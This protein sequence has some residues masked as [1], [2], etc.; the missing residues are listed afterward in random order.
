M[1]I[2]PT[3][4]F[5]QESAT[6]AAGQDVTLVTAPEATLGVA[7]CYDVRFPELARKMTLA[8]AKILIY[9]AAFGP[10]TG[11][12]H[13]ELLMRMRAVDNQ[14]FVVA[15]APALNPAANYKA[16]GHSLIVNPWGDIVAVADERERVL[17]ASINLDMIEKVRAELPLL[18]HRRPELYL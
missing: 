1:S 11:P 9:P 5:F 18:Q 14:V 8:G 10:V 4:R 12:A 17:T 16:Y 15:A 6:L 13:W 7:I 3:E 2:L